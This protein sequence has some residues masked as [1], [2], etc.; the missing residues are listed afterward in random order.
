MAATVYVGMSADLIH[1]GHLNVLKK[2]NELGRVIVGLLTDEA[3]ASYKRLPYLSYDQRREII[4]N[5]KGVDEVVP[6]ETLDYSINLRKY[7]PD[8]VVH[9]DD[10]KAGVQKS[11]RHK[12]IE[13][14]AE[15]DG[16][17]VEVPYTAGISSTAWNRHMREIGTTPQLR[18]KRMLR[19][20]GSKETLL[21]M[22]AHNG[23][24]AQI[25]ENAHAECNGRPTEF[26]GIWLSSLTDS[27]AKAKPDIEYVDKTSRLQTLND[28]LETSTKPIIFDGDTGGIAEH[29]AFTI[30]SLE[31]LGVS[32]II[33]EDKIGLK[34]NSLYGTD[35]E[36]TQDSIDRF[37]YKISYGKRAA[38]TQD[39][40]VIARIE[41]LILGKGLDDALE[42]AQ[43][44]LDA[45]ADGIFIHSRQK[46]GGE[47][48]E[49]CER[50]KRMGRKAPLVVAPSSF[51]ILHKDELSKAGVNIIIYA[52]HLLRS[53]YPAMVD[54]A[55]SILQNGRSHEAE[56]SLAPI[57]EFLKLIPEEMEYER[58]HTPAT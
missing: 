55:N 48:L 5:L 56:S 52:N 7:K 3:I 19:L 50:Y 54:T 22:E 47:I 26:D 14:L 1:P 38:V 25:V 10:W 41:S 39:F 37:C 57:A 17:L 20:L 16:L 29:F 34:K 23:L 46:D 51:S 15:W 21:F 32:A 28:I 31:R 24:S 36:Q 30:R 35:V 40:L 2:A 27:Y 13:T 45:G 44:Y 4:L 58:P 12:V 53:A 6:Q 42:R 9:G 49:F 11:T 8:Y 33:V 43:K 18:M